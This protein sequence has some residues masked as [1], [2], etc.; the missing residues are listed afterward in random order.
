MPLGY[1]FLAKDSKLY[2]ASD[3]RRER[4]LGAVGVRGENATHHV[5]KQ[6]QKI[7]H[8]SV[9]RVMRAEESAVERVLKFEKC[10]AFGRAKR[11]LS[12]V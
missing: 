6:T 2:Q 12:H 7:I 3:L 9:S 5:A 10:P 1:R 8:Y 4:I 11:L